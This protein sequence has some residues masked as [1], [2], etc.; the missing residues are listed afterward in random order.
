MISAIFTG[1]IIRKHE[2]V[3][4]S[5]IVLNAFIPMLMDTGGNS[6]SQSSTLVIRGLALGDVDL[7]DI[8][9]VI[10][11]E[12]RISLLVGLS[13]SVVN[14]FRIYFFE[15][16]GILISLTVSITLFLTVILS[17]VVGGILPISS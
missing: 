7:K 9:K 16:V 15:Q 4:E 17:K 14:F 6:A 5:V 2:A 13:L 11:K 3:L 10:W 8:G 1:G 12:F